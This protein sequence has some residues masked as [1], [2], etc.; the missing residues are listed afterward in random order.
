MQY[1]ARWLAASG[2]I[3]VVHWQ[4]N[5][6]GDTGCSSFPP[7]GALELLL[8]MVAVREEDLVRDAVVLRVLEGE[9]VREGVFDLGL[10][11]SQRV[12]RP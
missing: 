5:A 4:G 9:G 2:T 1:N 10:A 12:P 11:N 7:E 8:E 6:R 3:I